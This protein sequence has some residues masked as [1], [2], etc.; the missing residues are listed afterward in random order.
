MY[1]VRRTQQ[2]DRGVVR[3]LAAY[4]AAALTA[5]DEAERFSNWHVSVHRLE[6]TDLVSGCRRPVTRQSPWS[7]MPVRLQHA[8]RAAVLVVLAVLLS[9]GL[10]AATS[11]SHEAAAGPPIGTAAKFVPL[12]PQRV[13][14]T[15]EG[16]G[17]PQARVP[18][19]GSVVLSV[20]GKGGVPAGGVS[21]VVLNVTITAS[22]GGGFVQVF[23][24][25]QS[26]PGAFSNINTTGAGQTIAGLVTAPVGDGGTVTLYAEP[27]GHLVADVFG[28]YAGAAQ[29][30]DGRYV[31]LAPARIL[32][33]RNGTTPGPSPS[34]SASP[35]PSTSPS[36][37]PSPTSSGPP[38]NPGDTKNC[39]DFQTQHEA[40]AW[41]DYY[42]PYYGDVAQL[43]G[44]NDRIA[45]ESL[46]ASRRAAVKVAP[47]SSITLQVTGQGG[48]PTTGAS[49]VALN[50][51]ATEATAPGF[52]QV[53]PTG[54]STAV[55]SSS[56]LNLTAAGQTIANLVVVPLGDAGRVTL[57]S[58]G[59]AHLLA[60]V[61]G[62]FTDAS[63]AS[64]TTGLFQAIQPGRLLD[65]REGGQAKPGD[66]SSVVVDPLGRE[67]VPAAGVSGVVLNVTAVQ[68]VAPGFVQVFP[69]GRATA[70]TSSNVNITR[71]GQVIA[72]SALATLGDG[73]NV[74]LYTSRSTHL[75][76]DVFGYYLGDGAIPSTASPSPSAGSG[77]VVLQG[78]QVA[79]QNTSVPYDRA[80]WNH[81]IDA[82]GDC[83]DTRAEVLIAES[84]QTPTF[85][86][87]ANCTVATGR[88]VDPY[89]GQAWTSAS[90]VDIDHLVALANAHAS[91]AYAWD[92]ARKQ[93]YANDLADPEHLIAVEDNVNQQK[94][95]SGP[96][97][98]RPPLQAYWCTYATDWTNVKKRWSLTATQEEYNALSDMLATC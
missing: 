24:T 46:P 86:T 36:P 6:E 74:T 11:S 93:A 98:W 75:V 76:A 67:G 91:G 43:D 26:T 22:G 1:V 79:P 50:V 8:R 77:Q 27:G 55:A 72:N 69:T 65:T 9:F 78:L 62:Y 29:S 40:Q 20:L 15:R 19:R 80:Q 30:A 39:S 84:T 51:T 49:A 95:A 28:Y 70:G 5:G 97:S 96:E 14:D 10:D 33:T 34:P 48:V 92:A 32:D 21:A 89:T 16:L 38:P 12:Q 94:G 41:F 83:Q 68:P 7:A 85:T 4:D 31:A 59:G 37:Q 58:E 60:D 53:I 81:W 52:V 35:S 57:Y 64:G 17:A 23:P 44:D 18:A 88:W 63:A 56:N 66:Q 61:A 2:A 87:A 42:Y 47:H 73:G 71:A 54:G 45:C 3:E 13:L 25:G 90:D 82:D